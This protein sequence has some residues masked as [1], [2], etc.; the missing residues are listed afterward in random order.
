VPWDPDS[1]QT[2]GEYVLSK[3]VQVRPG[4]WTLTT[5]DQVT[6]GR[7]PAGERFKTVTDQLGN[8]VTERTDAKGRQRKDVHINLG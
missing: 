4:G 2:F 6:E 1:G 3:V 7:N 5:R 8:Q